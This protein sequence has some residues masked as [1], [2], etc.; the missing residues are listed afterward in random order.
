MNILK[1]STLMGVLILFL[2]VI[3]ILLFK[4][5]SNEET[6]K[7]VIVVIRR[8]GFD[9]DVLTI[10][11][12]TTVT[13]INE[14]SIPHTVASEGLFDSGNLSTGEKF[15]FPFTVKG[16]YKYMCTIHRKHISGKI[17]VVEG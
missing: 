2:A 13:W 14:D 4:P 9:P 15:S 5:T 7:S 1:R 12:G 16:I 11:V 17:I 3:F 10:P 8:S 6:E